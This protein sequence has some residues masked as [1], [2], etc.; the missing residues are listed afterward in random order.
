MRKSKEVILKISG[1]VILLSTIG[2][3]FFSVI[4]PWIM[5][6]GVCLFSTIVA[7]TPYR[8]ESIRGKRL[9]GLELVACTLMAA[10]TYFMFQQRNEWAL[11]MVVAAILLFY[12]TIRMPK[13]LLNENNETH[14]DS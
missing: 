2:Y 13:E 14:P 12:T 6:G 7:T 9:H 1:V 10:S 5:A 4:A 8:G 3:S 11:I